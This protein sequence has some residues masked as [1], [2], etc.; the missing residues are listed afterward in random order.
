MMVSVSLV[1]PNAFD[2]SAENISYPFTKKM[3]SDEA[4]VA[5]L[6]AAAIVDM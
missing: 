4:S 3:R 2:I 5:T 6:V 1:T